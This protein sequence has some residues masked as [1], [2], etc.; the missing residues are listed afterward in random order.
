MGRVALLDTRL[1]QR[2]P[3]SQRELATPRTFAPAALWSCADKG[4]QTQVCASA[5]HT[6]CCLYHHQQANAHGWQP[7][8]G[9]A[10]PQRKCKVRNELEPLENEPQQH[11][12][13]AKPL[14]TE[15][16]IATAHTPPSAQH[17]STH[18]ALRNALETQLPLR[19]AH[20]PRS[21]KKRQERG[22]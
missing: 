11:V 14:H 12:Y 4:V 2:L 6:C 20:M 16:H 13:K 10:K 17:P 15:T 3:G 7:Y 18:Q 22:K 19:I 21:G 9:K 5:K 8:V 1:N